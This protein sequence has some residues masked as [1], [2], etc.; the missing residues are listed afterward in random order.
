MS[1]ALIPKAV[2]E[3]LEAMN[4]CTHHRIVVVYTVSLVPRPR[5]GRGKSGLVSNVCACV[6][7]SVYF[8]V[9]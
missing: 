3:R 6:E 2:P 5:K 1:V 9:N 4:M 8:L 7:F